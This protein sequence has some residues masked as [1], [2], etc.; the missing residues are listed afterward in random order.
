VGNV[1]AIDV[2]PD[3]RHVELSYTLGVA[4]LQRLGLA[5]TGHGR[6][7][8]IA[9]PPELRVQIASN[10]LT[11]NR[12]LQI[13]FFD[14]VGTPLP[15]LPFP[16]PD[17]YIP[18]APS[19]LK[20]LEGSVTRAVEQLPELSRAL[21]AVATRLEAILGDVDRRGLPSRSVATLDATDRLLAT[22]Q[23]KLDQLP[24]A[25]LSREAGAALRSSSQTLA[26]LDRTLARLDGAE[27]L[28]ASVQRAS[29][30]LGDLAGARLGANLDETGR[31]LREAA[32]AVRQLAEA[33]QRDPDMLLKGK[34]MVTQ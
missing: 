20:N 8:R 18:A 21:T 17:N 9:V 26:A 1:S 5:S 24:V 14:G 10:G 19:T 33:L 15:V 30:A 22:L 6:Q 28:L 4:V 7:T 16:V 32:V 25:D 12:Y 27:G 2:A 29:D 31:D 11:G 13:D 34:A 3:R 23:G